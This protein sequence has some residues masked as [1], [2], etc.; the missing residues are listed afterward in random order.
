[1]SQNRELVVNKLLEIQEKENDKT[2]KD[3]PFSFGF[4]L[5][6]ILRDFYQSKEKFEMRTVIFNAEN[7]FSK[8]IKF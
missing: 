3:K 5:Y 4:R 8:S 1:M 6:E 7:F 2:I